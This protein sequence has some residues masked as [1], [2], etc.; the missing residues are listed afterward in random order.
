[1]DQLVE[2]AGWGTT[3]VDDP[4]RIKSAVLQTV[5]LTV[6]P[7]DKCLSLQDVV[8]TSEYGVGQFCVGGLK[9]KGE[10]FGWQRSE[11]CC[12]NMKTKCMFVRYSPDVAAAV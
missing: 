2:V 7:A 8:G 1:M 5:S 6:V 12:V 9:G 10:S 3:D 11:I 4:D